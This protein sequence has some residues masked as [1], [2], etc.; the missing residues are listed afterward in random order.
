MCQQRAIRCLAVS[1]ADHYVAVRKDEPLAIAA[2]KERRTA[3]DAVFDHLYNQIISLGVMPGTKMSEAEVADQFGV[4]RQPVRDAFTR[5]GSMQL[6]HVQPQ[7]ATIVQKF[8]VS[9]IKTARLVRLGIELE[10]LR[11]AVENW[12]QD[13]HETFARNLAQQDTAVRQDDTARFHALDA[14]FH[15]IISQ[16]AGEPEAFELA[17]QKKVLV[18]RICVLSL[19]QADEMAVL[20]KDH[21]AIFAAMSSGDVAAAQASFREHLTRIDKTIDKVRESHSQFFED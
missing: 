20:V 8:S 1:F 15:K 12:S 6:L 16:V 10:I 4:S 18:D 2:L 21:Q 7:K 9:G 5:L 19:K 13:W 14:E 11:L 17:L 3:A